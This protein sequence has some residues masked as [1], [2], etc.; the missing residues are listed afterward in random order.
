MTHGV[1]PKLDVQ[2]IFTEHVVVLPTSS[3]KLSVQ[4]TIFFS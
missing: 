3:G 4:P 1:V 2:S